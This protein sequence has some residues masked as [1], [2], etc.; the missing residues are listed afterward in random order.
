MKKE[1]HL[2]ALYDIDIA[3]NTFTWNEGVWV[4]QLVHEIFPHWLTSIAE[5]LSDREHHQ[6][7]KFL[8]DRSG[9]A[10]KRNQHQ[11]MVGQ[12]GKGFRRGRNPVQVVGIT[13]TALRRG[14]EIGSKR[15]D[16]KLPV[17][18]EIKV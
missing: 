7:T 1:K 11:E 12:P 4:D 17:G 13:S 18:Y 8:A 6:L 3:M 16:F 2:A 15:F 9:I 10:I 14:K 5:W